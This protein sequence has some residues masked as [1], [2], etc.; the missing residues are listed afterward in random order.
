[1]GAGFTNSVR[2]N[3]NRRISETY[4][5]SRIQAAHPIPK[6][7]QIDVFTQ[8]EEGDCARMDSD[9]RTVPVSGK[10]GG[11]GSPQHENQWGV[12]RMGGQKKS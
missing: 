9:E 7:Q 5:G 1:M 3:S 8:G 11:V 12:L 10:G 6:F 2:R 4:G